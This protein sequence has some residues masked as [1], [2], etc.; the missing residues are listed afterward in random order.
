MLTS[1]F[2]NATI[3]DAAEPSSGVDPV[4]SCD[5]PAVPSNLRSSGFRHD[6]G[7]LIASSG[8]I[9]GDDFGT[10][11]SDAE[12]DAAVQ[13]FG[14]DCPACIRS[15]RQLHAQSLSQRVLKNGS[16]GHCLANLQRRTSPEQVKDVLKTLDAGK[17]SKVEAL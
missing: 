6:R 1:L 14:C 10:D 12:S 2:M 13:L 17:S 9:S 8:G 5:A 15:L 3:A 4:Q 16:Q 7:T 11:F